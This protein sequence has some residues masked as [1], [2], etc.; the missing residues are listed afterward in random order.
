M[1]GRR[2]DD[3]SATFSDTEEIACPWCGEAI[4]NLLEYAS[5]D[6]TIEIECGSCEKTV[7]LTRNVVVTYAATKGEP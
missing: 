2:G 6:S 7:A 4:E 5:A 3:V 1:R